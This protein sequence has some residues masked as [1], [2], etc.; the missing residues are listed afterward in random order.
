M[1]DAST[2]TRQAGALR[3]FLSTEAAAGVAVIALAVVALVWANGPV[4]AGYTTFFATGLGRL[5]VHGWVNDGLM[6]LFFLVVGLEIKRELVVG[7]LQDRRA[8]ALPALAAL[9]G[10]VVPAVLFLALA[11]DGARRGWGAPMATDIAFALGVVGLLGDRVPAGAKLFLLTLAIVDDLG[12]IAAIAVFYA[13]KIQ[14]TW[15]LAAACAV[16]GVALLRGRW[17]AVVALG[18]LAWW[19]TL[20]SGVH[21]TIAG[22]ALG[23]VIPVSRGER[24][25]ERLHPFTSFLVVPVFALANAGVALTGALDAPGAGRLAAAVAVSLVLGKVLGVGGGTWLGLRLG[26]G[27]LPAGVRPRHMAG[28]AA[29]AGVGFTVSLFVLDIAYPGSQGLATGARLGVLAA[30]TVAALLGALLLLHA[31]RRHPTS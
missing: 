28:I 29:I 2:L 27:V 6:T 19:C 9:G 20:E 12:A 17:W 21:P 18:P 5:D 15:L 14:P 22:V 26:I 1:T 8:A 30:S 13:E 24:Y 3:R 10:M 31:C 7:E 23:L 11:G 4:A 25:E 16:A